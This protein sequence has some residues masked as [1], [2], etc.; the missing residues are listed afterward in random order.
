[1][2]RCKYVPGS[3]GR[4]FAHAKIGLD[5]EPTHRL[6]YEVLV[7]FC[8]GGRPSIKIERARKKA[9][10]LIDR[11]WGKSGVGQEGKRCPD[12]AHPWKEHFVLVASW[13]RGQQ[14]EWE[15]EA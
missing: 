14:D 3:F 2:G 6:Y 5:T 11:G 13:L 12:D 1:M 15:G 4:A 8:C 10:S 7:L 9:R